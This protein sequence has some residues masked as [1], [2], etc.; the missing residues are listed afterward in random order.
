MS[1]IENNKEIVRRLVEEVWN[2][3]NLTVADLLTA[4]NY[5]DHTAPAGWPVGP[6]GLRQAVAHNRLTFPDLH[7]TIE[8]LVAEGDRVLTRWT[9]HG[10]HRGTFRH[11]VYGVVPPTGSP[12]HVTGMSLRRVADGQIAELWGHSDISSMMQQLGVLAPPH[13]SRRSSL[14]QFA[15]KVRKIV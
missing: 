12:V 4:P 7:Y 15:D 10:T 11:R 1:L 8:E 5:V 3:G 9:M 13:P 2:T 14:L 6:A